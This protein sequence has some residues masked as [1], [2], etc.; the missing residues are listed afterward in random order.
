VNRGIY[1][2]ASYPKS[3]NTWTRAFI[4]NLRNEEPEEV[5]INELHTGAIAS[6]RCWVDEVLGFESGD[7][8]PDESDLLR[9]AVYRWYAEQAEELEYH[10]IHD[11]YTMLAS[12]EPL[13]PADATRGALCIIRNP[14]D[15]AISFAHHSSCSIDRAIE[16]MG[17]PD[18][19]FCKNIKRQDNQL[20]QKMLSWSGHVLS[21]AD[22]TE[23]NRLVVR[24]EDMKTDPLTT[25][26]RMAGFLQLPVAR[27]MIEVALAKC[28]FD[29]LQKQEQEK[30]F[31]EKSPKHER[32]FRKGIVGDWQQTLT[33]EQ[34]ERIVADHHVV[35]QRFGYLDSLGNPVT[36]FTHDESLQSGCVIK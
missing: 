5:D 14:L 23:I 13:I 33:T 31:N 30:G 29:K 27:D 9:P 24:Y 12:G 10:K 4:A 22:A 20:R 26:T 28:A 16:N 19:V 18:F 17:N 6:G 7:L 25:F 34:I 2:L 11:A 32:F 1:W 36:R 21:W 35:M 15:V 3:G 8:T